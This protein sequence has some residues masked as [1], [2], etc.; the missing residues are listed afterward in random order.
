MIIYARKL[1]DANVF[2]PAKTDK[3]EFCAPVIHAYKD[4]H[5]YMRVYINI[6]VCLNLCIV[7]HIHIPL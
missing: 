1:M 6:H 2:K 4:L 5:V 7:M 3:N